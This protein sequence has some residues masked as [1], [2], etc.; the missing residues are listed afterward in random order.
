MQDKFMK[1][2]FGLAIENIQ[3]GRGGPFA[4]L[5]VKDGEVVARGTNLVTSANDPTAHAEVMAIRRACAAL[6]SFQLTGCDLY[7]TCEPCPMCLGAIYWARLDRVFFASTRD[8]AADA[9]F[10]DAMLYDELARPLAARSIPMIPLMTDEG[11]RVFNAWQ[12]YEGR[13][14]Y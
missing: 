7:T 13:V 1:E 2:A 4:A 6:R 11:Q 9:G 12:H 8:D 3:T 5:V 14:E 10:D